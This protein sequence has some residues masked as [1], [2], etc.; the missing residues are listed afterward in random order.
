MNPLEII[1][2]WFDSQDQEIKYELV[3]LSSHFHFDREIENQ[4]KKEDQVKK[5]RE[6]L[7]FKNLDKIE[8][9]Q[10]TL[11]IIKLIDFAI[12]GRDSES[13]WTK[14]MDKNLE[15]RSRMAEK[16]V[17]TKII[18]DF[19]ATYNSRKD[20]WIELSAEWNEMVNNELSNENIADWYF[21]K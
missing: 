1:L 13:G 8:S 17:P 16:G 19:L 2:K 9:V 11:F 15:L 18:D 3:S 20:T 14:T 5:F 7:I 12:E 21:W 6:Y 4:V 10:R